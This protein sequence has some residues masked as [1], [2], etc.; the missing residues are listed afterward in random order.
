[1]KQLTADWLYPR[2]CALC[3]RL[4]NSREPLVCRRCAAEVPPFGGPACMCCGRPLAESRAQ[5][6]SPEWGDGEA[7]RKEYCADCRKRR[8]LFEQG[9]APYIYRGDIQASLL[10]MKYAGRAEYAGFYAAS[11]WHA[12]KARICRWKPDVIVPVPVHTGR[13]MKRGY[14][15][16]E[17]LA[18]CL[19]GLSGIPVAEPVL[20]VRRTRPQR[21]L[22]PAERRENVRGAF[23][24]RDGAEI[25]AGIL[26]TDDIYT[27]G[28][29]L[30]EIAGVLLRGG[31]RKVWFAC[32]AAASGET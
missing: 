9:F 20:R 2:H 11:I 19:S 15:Q 26:L 29:T 10:R 21:G 24:L 3:D 22:T 31:A 5:E 7:F 30:D 16:A 18:R 23:C 12:G 25:P 32:A 6:L 8:H 14:N 4:L 28:S 13:W 1:M 27:T 17:E